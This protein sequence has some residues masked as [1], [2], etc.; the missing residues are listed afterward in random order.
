MS[1]PPAPAAAG[2]GAGE[3]LLRVTGA[4]KRFSGL[5]ALAGADLTLAAGEV[6]GLIGPNGS[7]KTTL[8]NCVSGALRIDEGEIRLRGRDVT[9]ASRARRARS[10]I[11]RTFQ[12]LKLFGDL[13]V[14]EN[15]LVGR[16]ASPRGPSGGPS[17]DGGAAPAET[18]KDDVEGLLRDLRLEHVAREI[19]STLSYGTQRRVEIARALAG[20]PRVL[21]L[22]EPAAGLNDGETAELKDLIHL[23]RT[24]RGC[25]VLVIDH[26]MNLV[27]GIS[28]RVQVLDEGTVIF[29]GEPREAFEQPR[30][31]AAYL[32][33]Q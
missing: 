21:L 16:N 30:V 29:E 6:L 23:I 3:P 25:G 13:T 5:T 19:V 1:A 32:G 22:D 17:R 14:R 12:N 11:A 2:P 10:G 24:E 27:L 33:A 8:V 9:R 26:D 4:V 18:P 20:N 28:D 15:V 7:G 31:V